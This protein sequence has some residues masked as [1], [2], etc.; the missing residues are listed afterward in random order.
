M[1]ENRGPGRPPVGGKSQNVRLYVRT[2]D[3]E[4]ELLEQAA[5]AAG[6]SLSEWIRDRL[7]KTA[8]RELKRYI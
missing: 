8:Q 5:Q 2:I 6:V 4:K 1:N 3:N 7:V